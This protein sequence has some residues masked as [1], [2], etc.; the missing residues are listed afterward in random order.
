MHGKRHMCTCTMIHTNTHMSDRSCSHV[1][2]DVFTCVHGYHNVYVCMRV[3]IRITHLYIDTDTPYTIHVY[4]T[5]AKKNTRTCTTIYTHTRMSGHSCSVSLWMCV[6]VYMCVTNMRVW[7]CVYISIS[8]VFALTRSRIHTIHVNIIHTKRHIYKCTM[9][10]TNTRMSG[11][12][13]SLVCID[14]GTCVYV[15]DSMYVYVYV[16]IYVCMYEVYVCMYLCMYL[17]CLCLCL[18]CFVWL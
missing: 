6:S 12:S 5:H 16:C 3:C 2:M 8:Y 10:H 7:V 1:C 4:N 17:M 15:C 11:R 13:C 14:I 18:F 9:I